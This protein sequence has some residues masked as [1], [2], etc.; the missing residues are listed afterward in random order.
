DEGEIDTTSYGVTRRPHGTFDRYGEQS[1]LA[2]PEVYRMALPALDA[3][4]RARFGVGFLE[5]TE[6]R[7]DEVL[8]D[9][10]E[11]RAPTFGPAPSGRD[12]FALLR[13]HTIEGMFSD[14]IYGGNRD[15]VG[16]RLVGFPGAQ[17]AYSEAELRT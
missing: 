6:D 9:L 14:P 10:E 12:F 16:W 5:A 4:A 11:D 7:Q 3:H 13:Q 1:M 2:P 17:R 15:L 8:A